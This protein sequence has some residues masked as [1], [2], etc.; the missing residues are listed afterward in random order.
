MHWKK[1]HFLAYKKDTTVKNYETLGGN[2]MFVFR[3]LSVGVLNWELPTKLV[4]NGPPLLNEYILP[5]NEQYTVFLL[6]FHSL[7]NLHGP[8]VDW[9]GVITTNKSVQ[10]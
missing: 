7:T 3:M 1:F 6:T 4:E 9:I 10:F 5:E 8:S 2:E